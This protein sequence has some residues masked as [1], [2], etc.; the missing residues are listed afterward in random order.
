MGDEEGAHTVLEEEG[1]VAWFEPW[2]LMS[3]LKGE[4]P[5]SLIQNYRR[6]VMP[7]PA[8]ISHSVWQG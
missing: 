8:V 6:N 3:W 4:L 5:R 2:I 1:L 7:T